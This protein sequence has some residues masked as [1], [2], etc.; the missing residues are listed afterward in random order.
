MSKAVTLQS[1]HVRE[2]NRR[3]VLELLRN[4]LPWSRRELADATSLSFPTITAIGQE[5]LAAGL[6]EEVG[7]SQLGGG[8][9]A[10]LLQLVPDARTILSLDLGRE[11]VRAEVSD[12]LG[13]TRLELEGPAAA[14]GLERLLP[15]W[16]EKLFDDLGPAAQR[17][18]YLAV[19]V[20]G[21]VASGSGRVR[22]APALG[23]DDYPLAEVL[24]AAT[25]L[26]VLLAND[27]NAMTLA[28]HHYGAAQ[29]RHLL[30]IALGQGVGAGLITEGRLYQGSSSAAGEIGYSLL[31]DL[32]AAPSQ[33]GLPGPLERHWL[34]LSQDLLGAD[35]LLELGGEARR[36]AFERLVAEVHLI[37]HNLVCLLNPERL[38]VT[39]SA[40][41]QGALVEALRA[42]WNNPLPLTLEAGT[43][44]KE[45]AL[46]GAAH[47]ALGRLEQELCRNHM[48]HR[49]AGDLS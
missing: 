30:F 12:L 2:A 15:G 29:C 34:S 43:L 28:E 1:E 6:V 10:Q 18:S 48:L 41:P 45:A 19:A 31:P 14:P 49:L 22:L 7:Q 39:W 24:R 17:L 20:P 37:A 25:G 40:D 21:V 11:H 32:Q 8:R 27:V 16:L 38:I 47:L 35:G 13:Q 44:G 4:G 33:L 3:A 46:K 9:P 26:P 23:W 42:R 5:F 36:R